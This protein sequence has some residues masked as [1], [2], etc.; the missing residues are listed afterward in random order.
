MAIA[1]AICTHSAHAA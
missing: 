1:S